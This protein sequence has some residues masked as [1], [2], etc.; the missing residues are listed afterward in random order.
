M[1]KTLWILHSDIQNWKFEINYLKI[2]HFF[3]LNLMNSSEENEWHLVGI[4]QF[5]WYIVNFKS[6][7][8]FLWPFS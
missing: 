5:Y 3:Y 7:K 4:K 6:F 2:I 1:F 8:T